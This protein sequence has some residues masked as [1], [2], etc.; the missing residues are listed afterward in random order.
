M[1]NTTNSRLWN[2]IESIR[3]V[4]K[5]IKDGL[6]FDGEKVVEVP[7]EEIDLWEEDLEF[8][9]KKFRELWLKRTRS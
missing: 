5:E 6:M 7:K 8:Y 3:Q 2:L 4:R 9:I 1:T